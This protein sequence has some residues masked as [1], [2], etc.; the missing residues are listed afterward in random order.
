MPLHLLL[1]E[2]KSYGLKTG[3]QALQEVDVI[4]AAVVYTPFYLFSRQHRC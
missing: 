4:R 3:K 2:K 1:L